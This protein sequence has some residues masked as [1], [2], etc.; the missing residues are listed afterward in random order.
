MQASNA[1]AATSHLK[2]TEGIFL[3]KAHRFK[4]GDDLDNPCARLKTHFKKHVVDAITHQTT[5]ND[6]TKMVS[7]LTLCPLFTVKSVKSLNQALVG[8]CDT[9]D[10]Q[11]CNNAI[12]HFM[13]SLGEDL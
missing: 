8:L 5:P 4:T 1:K 7:V 3:D 13:S 2:R 10:E 11:N 12:E 9:C 6:M